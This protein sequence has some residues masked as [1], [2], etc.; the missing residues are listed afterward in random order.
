M[1]STDVYCSISDILSMN[2]KLFPAAGL[3]FNRCCQESKSILESS[4]GPSPPED[5]S[6]EHWEILKD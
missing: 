4:Y 2:C 3:I 6:T 1:E 5:L